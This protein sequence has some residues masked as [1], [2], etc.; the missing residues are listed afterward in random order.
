MI[1]TRFI[2]PLREALA[3]QFLFKYAKM[4]MAFC[5]YIKK[6]MNLAKDKV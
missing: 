4:R 1:I 6:I 3:I 2:S 5:H